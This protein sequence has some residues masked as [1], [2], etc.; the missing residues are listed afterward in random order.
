MKKIIKN[1]NVFNGK[2]Y[3][4]QKNYNIVIDN[5]IVTDIIAGDFNEENFDVVIDGREMTAIPGLI[6]CHTHISASHT[7]ANLD[8]MT[9]DE[10]AIRSVKIAEEM[11]YR[12]FTTV[13]D[14]GGLTIGL[15]KSIDNGYATG[16]RIFTSNAAISQTCGHSDYRQNRAQSRNILGEESPLM[17]SGIFRVADG[18]D[19][20]LKAVREQLFNGAS[21]I[22]LMAGGGASSIFDPLDTNQ[23]T[24]EEQ[25]AAVQAAKDYGT[26]VCAHIHTSPSMKRAAEAGIMCF[27]HASLMT[28]EV[29]K[30]VQ[31]KGIWI[32]GQYGIAELLAE[33]KY[34]LDS[35]ILYQKTERVG[36]GL[37]KQAELVVKYNLN[38]VFGTDMPGTKESQANQLSDFVARKKY[39]GSYE[40]LKQ[41]TGNAHEL[42]K[43]C[44]YQNPYPEGKVGVLEKRSFADLLLIDGNPLDNLE[45]IANKDNMKLIMKDGKIYK[46]TL[47]QK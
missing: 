25:K 41:A 43:L 38:S 34:P 1:V 21:Q 9:I 33:R 4:L 13:R 31:E 36:K 29:A 40:G 11:L 2:D 30:I 3:E 5:N 10:I 45:I 22:K 24:L 6:D 27:E 39:F 18:V 37:L 46:N 16:P 15:K 47:K 42:F 19:E 32:C 20:V 8:Q 44:T 14:V 17:K 35:E 28:E 26:Y 7:F 23:Y 12:G